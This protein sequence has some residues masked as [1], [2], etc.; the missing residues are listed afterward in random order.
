MDPFS[1]N[2][3][4]YKS[5]SVDY[6][7]EPQYKYQKSWLPILR[8]I[9]TD[10][11]DTHTDARLLFDAIK[12]GK[13]RLA[14]FILDA[15]PSD[16]ANS[17]DLK[18]KNPLTL[19][20]QIKEQMQRSEMSLLF[21]E[22]GTDV[23]SQDDHGRTTM[24]YACE[25]KCNDIVDILVRQNDVD[26]DLED[27]KGNTPLIYGSIVGNDVATDLLTRN[28]R[29]LGLEID[30]AN[31]N[32]FT[33]LLTA[34]KHGNISCARILAQ[35]GQASLHVRDKVHGYSVQ[36][37][38]KLGGYTLEDIVSE[39]K[40]NQ[41]KFKPKFVNALSI[42]RLSIP[43]SYNTGD[44]TSDNDDHRG[45]VERYS[46]HRDERRSIHR[47]S[48]Y[49]EDR[50]SRRDNIDRRGSHREDRRGSPRD[51]RRGSPR[52]DRRGSFRQEHRNSQREDKRSSF[53]D[54]K[55]ESLRR[56]R[57]QQSTEKERKE[58]LSREIVDL[59]ESNG[60]SGES[61]L[62]IDPSLPVSN[63]ML[64]RKSLM[65][66]IDPTVLK[67]VIVLPPI[68]KLQLDDS[69]PSDTDAD[70]TEV[71]DYEQNTVQRKDFICAR[72][73]LVRN[74]DDDDDSETVYTSKEDD[75]APIF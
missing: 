55:R 75:R 27:L 49:R 32:G 25:T 13:Y 10:R 35:Q 43:N 45:E 53:R 62:I 63:S 38:L 16:L 73:D 26:P 18:G 51:D 5:H 68:N 6:P 59:I 15:S 22:K 31:K 67:N 3:Y 70:N 34:A 21:L 58:M 20:C 2:R 1:S 60:N 19:C 50:G 9:Y 44:D 52:E 7:Y 66:V 14:K 57:K 42:T 54:E 47:Q 40:I 61:T 39:K 23:N 65:S 24:S 33:A 72:T 46:G 69:D 29:R 4:R 36:E 64:R 37:W 41:L 56:L 48:S 11:M 71:D 8:E 28:F 12:K 74:D 17:T 30:H